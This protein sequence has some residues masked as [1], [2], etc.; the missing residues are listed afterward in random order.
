[1]IGKHTPRRFLMLVL[2]GKNDGTTIPR[3]KS[4]SPNLRANCYCRSVERNL[5]AFEGLR[6]G[7]FWFEDYAWF[8]FHFTLN[9]GIIA[10][11]SILRFDFPKIA[12][13]VRP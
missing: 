3:D 8:A 6:A 13:D 10:L 11:G 9:I 12:I 2:A 1:M 7:V 5:Y 4:P